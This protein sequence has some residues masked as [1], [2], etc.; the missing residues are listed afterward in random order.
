MSTGAALGMRSRI[1]ACRSQGP[2]FRFWDV[3][4]S[5]ASCVVHGIVVWE[6]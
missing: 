5:R 4:A 1:R 2:E 3:S 6:S